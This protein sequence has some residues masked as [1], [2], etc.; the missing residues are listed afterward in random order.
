MAHVY[1]TWQ[2][3]ETEAYQR[4]A[5]ALMLEYD[6]EMQ[7]KYLEQNNAQYSMHP[8]LVDEKSFQPVYI[9]QNHASSF[10]GH[11]S[12]LCKCGDGCLCVGE[13]ASFSMIDQ[14]LTCHRV[15]LAHGTQ[16]RSPQ[17]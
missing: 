15:H 12:G 6:Q 1:E 7:Q 4:E 17:L 16:Q 2:L 8:Q 10:C 11:P 14:R 13:M 3:Q 9:P 5:E